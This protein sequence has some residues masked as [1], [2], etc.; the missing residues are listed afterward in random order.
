MSKSSCG[1]KDSE[2]I[3][4]KIWPLSVFPSES[5]WSLWVNILWYKSVTNTP[6][7][8]GP[9][10]RHKAFTAPPGSL[11]SPK[12]Q[13]NIYFCLQWPFIIKGWEGPCSAGPRERKVIQRCSCKPACF[14]SKVVVLL[15]K[16]GALGELL[17]HCG[18]FS[19]VVQS[20]CR[21]TCCKR[22]NVL[23][24]RYN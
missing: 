13:Q 4:L 16:N 5:V 2:L 6:H 12:Q 24:L 10:C 21:P 23:Q 20:S 11:S 8:P 1:S 14:L 17:C 9:F 22:L 19:L 18:T 7:I 15:F 3:E